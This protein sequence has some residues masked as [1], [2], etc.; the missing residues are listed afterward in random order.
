MPLAMMLSKFFGCVSRCGWSVV[1]L[2]TLSVA[3]GCSHAPPPKSQ[4]SELLERV[5]PTFSMT[6]LNG[7][8]IDTG[9]FEVPI[10]VKFFDADCSAC[11]RT[12]PATQELYQQKPD[13]A[14][15]G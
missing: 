6:S 8:A 1:S 7:T 14:V 3:L 10:V 11:A 15:I 12:L 5:M 2:G 4:P 13:V 9:G